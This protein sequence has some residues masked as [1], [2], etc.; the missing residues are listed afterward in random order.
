MCE[1][2]CECGARVTSGLGVGL[3][4]ALPEVPLQWDAMEE[5]CI[6]NRNAEINGDEV[7]MWCF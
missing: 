6:C 3:R 2:E 7:R 1:G 4:A 5:A